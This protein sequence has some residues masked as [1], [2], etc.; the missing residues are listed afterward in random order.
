ML[1]YT[2][3]EPLQHSVIGGT[4]LGNI[5]SP[6]SLKRVQCIESLSSDQPDDKFEC[7]NTGNWST[8]PKCVGGREKIFIEFFKLVN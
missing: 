5:D 2:E 4:V 6:G 7:Q 1:F 8:V 3:C